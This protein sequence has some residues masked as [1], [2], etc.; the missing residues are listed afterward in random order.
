VEGPAS[1]TVTR[2][3]TDSMWGSYSE[4]RQEAKRPYNKGGGR[5][6]GK[7]VLKDINWSRDGQL[8]GLPLAP[9]G[10]FVRKHVCKR[11]SAAPRGRESIRVEFL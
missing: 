10:W 8:T 1:R 7:R 3:W 5:S 6:V 4:A 2:K 9:W 11:P